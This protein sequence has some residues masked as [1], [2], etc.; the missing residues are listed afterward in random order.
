LSSSSARERR[1]D[2][3]GQSHQALAARRD[4]QAVPDTLEQRDPEPLLQA[5]QL[6][7]DGRLREV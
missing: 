6:V 1:E 5:A 3:L 4:Q 2:L 7:A